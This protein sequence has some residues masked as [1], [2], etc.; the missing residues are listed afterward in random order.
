MEPST[1]T[2]VGLLPVPDVDPDVA[3]QSAAH[4]SPADAQDRSKAYKV[5]LPASAAKT[6]PPCIAS[7]WFGPAP[8][9][10]SFN[11]ATESGVI[12][13]TRLIPAGCLLGVGVEHLHDETEGR[14]SS[15]SI[16]TITA[17]IR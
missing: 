17:A 4:S 14:D 15:R 5:L 11:R 2:E 13:C 16:A 7:G 9:Q 1:A 3:V 10:T 6:T 8:V 12:E